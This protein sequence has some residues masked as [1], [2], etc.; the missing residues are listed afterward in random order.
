P[1]PGLRAPHGREAARLFHS[2]PQQVA[3]I[4]HLYV[5]FPQSPLILIDMS[6]GQLLERYSERKSKL[7]R[8][9]RISGKTFQCFVVI[10]RLA[11]S[12]SGA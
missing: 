2:A 7:K 3:V 12:E 8:P 9:Y 10:P 11:E 6:F 5:S 4:F 1:G